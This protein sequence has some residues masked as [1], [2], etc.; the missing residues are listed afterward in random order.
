MR[1]RFATA[2]VLSLVVLTACPMRTTDDDAG[3]T[4]SLAGL[5]ANPAGLHRSGSVGGVALS[6]DPDVPRSQH[7]DVASIAAGIGAVFPAGFAL[8]DV[9]LLVA[10]DFGAL[11]AGGAGAYTV[12]PAVLELRY[13]TYL[14][15]H[16][17]LDVAY[18]D[19]LRA[20]LQELQASGALSHGAFVLTHVLDLFSALGASLVSDDGSRIVL[21]LATSTVVVQA[22]EVGGLDATQVAGLLASVADAER[23]DGRTAFVVN[24][25][26][27]LEPCDDVRAFREDGADSFDPYFKATPPSIGPGDPLYDLI[28]EDTRDTVFVAAAGNFGGPAPRQPGRMPEVASVSASI[29]VGAD[30]HP[31]SNRAEVRAPGLWIP[32]GNPYG[33]NGAATAGA[34]LLGGTSLAAPAVAVASVLD[35]AADPA[36]CADPMAGTWLA[37][38]E[39]DDL[40]L[41]DAVDAHCM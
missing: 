30:V 4:C 11:H 40:A 16:P 21:E 14:L 15:E 22:V 3:P 29:G 10:D 5:E 18:P 9:V 23:A 26:F 36:R 35:L 31:E 19:W 2:T 37:H 24:M 32:L 38:G 39:Y 8:Q 20:R 27:T 41:A 7:V 25:S 33:R 17:A 28:H 13:Q 34:V 6:D 12:D 1:L